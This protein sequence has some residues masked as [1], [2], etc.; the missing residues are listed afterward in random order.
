MPLD[1]MGLEVVASFRV[2]AVRVGNTI[3]DS[4]KSMLLIRLTSRLKRTNGSGSP[5][6]R[7]LERMRKMRRPCCET[8]TWPVLM[9]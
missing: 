2:D 5:M 8:D 9:I 6:T 7:D 4:R 3:H 1:V